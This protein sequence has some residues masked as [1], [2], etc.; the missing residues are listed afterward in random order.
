[1]QS[2]YDSQQGAVLWTL[3]VPVTCFILGAPSVD[4]CHPDYHQHHYWWF[5]EVGAIPEES[6]EI[7]CGWAHGFTFLRGHPGW[8]WR[9]MH[10]CGYR[11]VNG[12]H[13][14]T[15]KWKHWIKKKNGFTGEETGVSRKMTTRSYV[16]QSI[17]F[18]FKW[19]QAHSFLHWPTI[20][21][22]VFHPSHLPG[23]NMECIF[24]H[25]YPSRAVSCSPDE[26]SSRLNSS[27]PSFSLQSVLWNCL[28]HLSWM[29]QCDLSGGHPEKKSEEISPPSSRLQVSNKLDV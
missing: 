28:K 14:P 19:W 20:C 12:R 5:T 13:W 4:P 10:C 16:W 25:T 8:L 1:M 7:I 24:N 26:A 17:R 22:C 27:R 18:Y 3:T 15:T 9:R 21:F 2:L 6:E 23:I 29:A 11:S